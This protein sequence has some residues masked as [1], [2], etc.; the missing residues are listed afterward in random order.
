MYYVPSIISYLHPPVQ[1][2]EVSFVLPIT[3]PVFLGNTSDQ[4]FAFV[5]LPTLGSMEIVGST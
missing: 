1:H 3:G 5:L 2:L 4:S